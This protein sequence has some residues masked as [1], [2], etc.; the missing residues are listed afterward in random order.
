MSADGDVFLQTRTELFGLAYR[1][2]G[3]RADAEDVLQEA[4]LRWQRQS[5][6]EV[7]N[8]QAYL[9][10]LVT[11]LC[12]DSL[13]SARARREHYV[14]Q[15]LPEPVV[16]QDLDPGRA[17]E[18]ADSLSMAF[19]V[20]LEQLSPPERAA[21]LLHDVFDYGYRELGEILDRSETSC[22]QLVSRARQHVQAG[23]RRFDADSQRAGEMARKFGLACAQGDLAG[24][25]QLLADDVVVWTD[26]GGKAK[27]APK[28]VFGAMRAAR[29]LISITRSVPLNAQ[30]QHLTLN[31]QPGLVITE[32]HNVYS[33]VVLDIIEKQVSGV[34]IISN[35]DK[36][37]AVGEAIENA[38]DRRD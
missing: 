3:T 34:R 31:G 20:L 36:L 28:P 2:L 37:V 15:W 38:V 26:G 8:P 35:P 30:V 4:F 14:G 13:T 12:L 32:S 11:R 27:A 21:F 5:R 16:T 18:T 33:A 9:T 22:R 10:T 24:L 23:R 6:T 17:A 29:F 7:R 19:L 25:M 1:M